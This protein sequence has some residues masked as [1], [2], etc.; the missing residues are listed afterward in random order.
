[1]FLKDP[2]PVGIGCDHYCSLFSPSS[3][4]L[5]YCRAADPGMALIVTTLLYIIWSSGL[6][7]VVLSADVVKEYEDSENNGLGNSPVKR[8]NGER[9]ARQAVIDRD[10]HRKWLDGV[11]YVFSANASDR[12][13]TCFRKA[14]SAWEQ[15]S[16]INFKEFGTEEGDYL[17]VT[18]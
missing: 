3:P 11:N 16:C 18:D 13:K 14:A 4:S 2:F 10:Q 6:N 7:P 17:Y 15:D 5:R 9:M 12:L 8:E 1:M